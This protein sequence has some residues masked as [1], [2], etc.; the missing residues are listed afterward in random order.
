MKLV[1]RGLRKRIQQSNIVRGVASSNGRGG[2]SRSFVN[3]FA[4]FSPSSGVYD[5]QSPENQ[6]NYGLI[7]EDAQIAEQR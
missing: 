3:N 2:I 7:S 5:P 1:S 6:T 4:N